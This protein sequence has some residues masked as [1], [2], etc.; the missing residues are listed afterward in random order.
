MV[1]DG[2]GSQFMHLLRNALHL[3]LQARSHH[4][5]GCHCE[6]KQSGFTATYR[7]RQCLLTTRNTVF[8]IVRAGPLEP[9]RTK[10]CTLAESRPYLDTVHE[11][12]CQKANIWIWGRRIYTYLFMPVYSTDT[13][14]NA[15]QSL[16]HS[17]S[18]EFIS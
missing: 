8:S 6:L 7:P 14:I 9:H 16:P 17:H 11:Y 1:G 13:Q 18:S 2:K 10:S 4:C 3:T 12:D 15:R 5:P